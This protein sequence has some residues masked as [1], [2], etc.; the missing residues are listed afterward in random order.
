MC[1]YLCMCVIACMY[2]IV[3][4]IREFMYRLVDVIKGWMMKFIKYLMDQS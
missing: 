4:I 3:C 2:I 1:M